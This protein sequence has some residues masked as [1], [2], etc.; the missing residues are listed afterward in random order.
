MTL[1]IY[2]HLTSGAFSDKP[3]S[4]DLMHEGNAMLQAISTDLLALGHQLAVMRDARL[5]NDFFMQPQI[6]LVEISNIRQYERAWQ[7]ARS[8]YQFFFI[9]APETNDV[10]GQLTHELE[11]YN[12]TVF[13]CNSSSIQLC[14]D[15]LDCFK[16][17]Q[18]HA[19]ASPYTQLAEDWQND[20]KQT[21][22]HWIVKPRDGAGCEHTYRLNTAELE[23]SLPAL[24]KHHAQQYIVQPYIQGQNLSLSL[25]ISDQSIELV[26][27]NVQHIEIRQ[28]KLSLLN[29]EPH[30][31]D[32]LN[33]KRALE[34]AN[35]I[36]AT[37]PGLWGFVGI[38]LIQT[39]D[40]LW[41]ID[42]NP[43]LT[44]SY[45]EAAMREH[46]NPATLLHQNLKHRLPAHY[47]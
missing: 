29:C 2:E 37:M 42:I 9:I 5:N 45:A 4:P 38:D 26:S 44:S 28:Q 40:T 39:Q 15:K 14:S 31:D 33:E 30:R 41:I 17:L 22:G 25:F 7:R 24:I 19:L 3:Y 35:T 18:Q 11:H 47:E 16:H 20:N 21:N 34:L 10:L 6:D 13:G 1:F 12:K 23:A 8:L 46:V 36:H 32:L 43:R 27:I